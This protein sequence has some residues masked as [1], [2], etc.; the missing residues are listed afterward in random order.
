MTSRSDAYDRKII[1][2]VQVD[3][4]LSTSDIGARVGLSKSAVQRRLASLRA[5]GRIMADIAVPDPTKLGA[6][7]S[8]VLLVTLETDRPSAMKRFTEEVGRT[9]E[10]QQCYHVTGPTDF[11]LIVTVRDQEHFAGVAGDLLYGNP[12]VLRFETCLVV[13]RT[14]VGLGLPMK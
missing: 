3:N 5:D 8:F 4:Q 13:D 10:V 12:D 1:S 14:K 11:I 2:V 7:L 6:F 9:G